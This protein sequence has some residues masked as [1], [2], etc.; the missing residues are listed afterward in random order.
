MKN[1]SIHDCLMALLLTIK[2]NQVRDST[3]II[4][5]DVNITSDV[6]R[7]SNG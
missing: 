2:E 1:E 3:T 5:W 4:C 7:P 6:T